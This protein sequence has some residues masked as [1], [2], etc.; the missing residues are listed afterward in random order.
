MKSSST[1]SSASGDDVI[2][3]DMVLFFGVFREVAVIL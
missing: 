1:S 3:E 2:N